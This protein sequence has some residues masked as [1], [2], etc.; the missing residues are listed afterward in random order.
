MNSDAYFEGKKYISIKEASRITG[1]S[2]DYI[3][4]LCRQDKITSRRIDRSW[5][6]LEESVLSYRTTPDE[7][8]QETQNHYETTTSRPAEILNVLKTKDS[9][10]PRNPLFS[11]HSKYFN[12][13]YDKVGHIFQDQ[14][15]QITIGDNEY[16]N[17]LTC[18]LHQ[19]PKIGGIVKN[20]ENYKWSSYPEFIGINS[21]NICDN[22]IILSQF[23]DI[24]EF[25]D[26]TKS[27]YEILK[28]KA[29]LKDLVFD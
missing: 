4:Q 28:D 2:R 26:F 6:V 1:Y 5:F 21:N 27:S 11:I 29:E 8:A 10:Q 22:E 16:L 7:K 23:K 25:K 13:K 19:N 18:Y 15:K 14:F 20:I 9:H 24:A 17:W 12:R 3:G